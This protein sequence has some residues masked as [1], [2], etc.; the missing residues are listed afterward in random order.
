VARDAEGSVWIADEKARVL[1]A[2]GPEGWRRTVR[3]DFF[4]SALA[5]GPGGLFVAQATGGE[6]DALV[7]VLDGDAVVPTTIVPLRR[8]DFLLAML[9][10]HVTLASLP[11]GRVAA[12]HMALEPIAHLWTREGGARIVALPFPDG[13]EASL[14]YVPEMP[15]EDEDLAQI[16]TGALSL[17]VD[18]AR[19]EL[20]FL[21]RSGRMVQ[22]A[23]ERAIIRTDADFGYLRS[24]LLDVHAVHMVYLTDVEAVIVVDELDRWF[25][26]PA[27]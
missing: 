26:C 2:F 5:G 9:Y 1:K 3:T 13:A 16:P 24:Y 18:R 21:T 27:A 15:I 6:A 17:S 8:P 12:A 10:N 11:G 14:G 19:N 4:A 7:H 25:R 23:P 20:L 22:D